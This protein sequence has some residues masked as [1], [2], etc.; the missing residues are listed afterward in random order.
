MNL[1][2]FFY[3]KNDQG[4]EFGVDSRVESSEDVVKKLPLL[5]E[6]GDLLQNLSQMFVL[7]LF[8]PWFVE[9]EYEYGVSCGVGD[10]D[11]VDLIVSFQKTF[12]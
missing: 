4:F 11:I 12:L 6:A 7:G 5:P 2:T 1:L 9:G 3:C 10:C 8:L